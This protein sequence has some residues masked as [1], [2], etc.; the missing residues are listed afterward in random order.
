MYVMVKS[1]T[2]PGR[3][4]I[5][6]DDETISETIAFNLKQAGYRPLTARDGLEG[7]R[8]LRRESP[9]LIILDLM[10][11]GMDGWKLLE[12]AREEGYDLPVIIVSA[13]TSEYD[14]VHGLAI[15]ADDYLTKPFSMKELMARV[16]A[17]L[18]R[19]RQMVPGAHKT[20]AITADGLTV[21][22]ERKEAFAN[23]DPLEL[24]S[25]EFSVL[26]LLMREAPMVISREDIYKAVWGYEMLHGDRSVDVFVRRIRKKL[27]AKLPDRSFLQTHY[28]FGY[29]FEVKET[30]K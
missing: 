17:Q 29:K 23:G 1:E 6:E 8:L 2:V 14:K 18:R 26:H 5:I 12:Q 28:G 25:K 20:G 21:D 30:S 4:L 7:L 10:L 19:H 24:T 22:P 16:E 3:V 11:P 9:D 15:G 27:G 13:R